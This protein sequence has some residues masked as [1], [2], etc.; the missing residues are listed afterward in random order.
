MATESHA[1]DTTFI[2]AEHDFRFS[3]DDAVSQTHWW[4]AQCAAHSTYAE[5][6]E[7]CD[8]LPE[9]KQAGFSRQLDRWALAQALDH[10]AP[11]PADAESDPQKTM[12]GI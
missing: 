5:W 3:K 2:I 7:C 8:S 1:P 4:E 12:N 11:Y 9:S 10:N 6:G